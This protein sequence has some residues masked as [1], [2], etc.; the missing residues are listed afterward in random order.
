MKND[1]TSQTRIADVC[2]ADTDDVD[3]HSQPYNIEK[4]RIKAG[5]RNKA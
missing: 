2:R 1:I 4:N 5:S 3:M